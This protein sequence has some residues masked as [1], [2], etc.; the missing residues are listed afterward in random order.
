MADPSTA[1]GLRLAIPASGTPTNVEG[2]P[3]E[4]TDQNRADGFSPAS[5]VLTF[6]PGVDL[7]A[8]GVAPSTDIGASLDEAAP[9][10]LTDLT[11]GER[12]P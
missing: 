2:V 5:T 1:T 3:L 10:T 8:S 6:V 12:W 9:I 4:V 7:E 11:A